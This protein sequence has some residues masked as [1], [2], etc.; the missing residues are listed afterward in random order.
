MSSRPTSQSRG[1]HT[2]GLT[3]ANANG[4]MCNVITRSDIHF[5]DRDLSVWLHCTTC[6]CLVSSLPPPAAIGN[7][8]ATLLTCQR[9]SPVDVAYLHFMLALS[10][11]TS[12]ADETGDKFA[13]FLLSIA[14]KLDTHEKGKANAVICPSVG[15]SVWLT[16]C[17]ACFD[18]C[19]LAQAGWLT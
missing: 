14:F 17:V 7:H 16:H 3:D 13:Q 12:A 15:L 18:L 19:L 6:P 11:S 1:R 8:D 10:L 4:T 5:Y 2:D 9:F